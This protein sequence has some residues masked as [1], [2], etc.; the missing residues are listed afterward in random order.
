MQVAT[1][2]FNK[3]DFVSSPAT[4]IVIFEA[5]GPTSVFILKEVSSFDR[6]VMKMSSVFDNIPDHF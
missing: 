1:R 2:L 4:I 3:I 6:K 5:S